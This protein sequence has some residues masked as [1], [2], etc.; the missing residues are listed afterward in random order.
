M[1]SRARETEWRI[2][3]RM[4]RGL[5]WSC[6]TAKKA[7]TSP[8]CFSQLSPRF[9][10]DSQKKSHRNLHLGNV[11]KTWLLRFFAQYTRKCA[12]LWVR[13]LEEHKLADRIRLSWCHSWSHLSIPNLLRATDSFFLKKKQGLCTD[14]KW[15]PRGLAKGLWAGQQQSILWPLFPPC[16]PR[17]STAP[18]LMDMVNC[19]VF[20]LK[21]MDHTIFLDHL[22][23]WWRITIYWGPS[24]Q[25]CILYP[26][27]VKRLLPI[28]NLHQ[29]FARNNM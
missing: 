23:S 3:Q 4:G 22:R 8:E 1:T 29:D 25:N 6:C 28:E 7:R 21:V 2:L 18:K 5:H 24:D 14:G 13:H 27:G 10:C 9:P 16:F 19:L 26:I 11:V 20:Y 12:E 15:Y 17:A